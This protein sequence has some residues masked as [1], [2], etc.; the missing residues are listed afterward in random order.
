MEKRTILRKVR[1][2]EQNGQGASQDLKLKKKI[3][4]LN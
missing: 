3:K 1:Q 4:K 2:K